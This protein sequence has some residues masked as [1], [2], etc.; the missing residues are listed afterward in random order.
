M[1]L[2]RAILLPLVI[3]YFMAG[4]ARAE[5]GYRLWLRYDPIPSAD[6][7][8]YTEIVK[9]VLVPGS[10]DILDAVRSE[11]TTACRSLLGSQV[12]VLSTESI[13]GRAGTVVVGTPASSSVI[14]SLNLQGELSRLG[15]EAVS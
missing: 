3:L 11:M 6:R 1:K 14:S 2:R 5:D 4:L 12:D 8:A 9:Q 7:S 10:T 15:P 13:D